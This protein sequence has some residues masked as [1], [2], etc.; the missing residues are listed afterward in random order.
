MHRDDADHPR[1]CTLCFLASDLHTLVANSAN[2]PFEPAIVRTRS[3]WARGLVGGDQQDAQE[4]F[5]ALLEACD[6]VDNRALQQHL[7]G[8]APHVAVPYT[9]PSWQIFGAVTRV[10]VTCRACQRSTIQYE[11]LRTLS[12]PLPAADD[13]R[14]WRIAP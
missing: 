2:L 11:M 3:S 4:A 12:V 6:G 9:T 1:S 10:H 7:M 14:V 13:D 5:N 8:V